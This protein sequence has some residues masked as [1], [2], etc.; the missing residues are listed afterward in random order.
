MLGIGSDFT[1]ARPL[2]RIAR[3]ESYGTLPQDNF[4]EGTKRDRGVVLERIS[5]HELE[6]VI[7][8]H[9]GYLQHL[10][11]HLPERQ[12]LRITHYHGELK[13]ELGELH[14]KGRS[15]NQRQLR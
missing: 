15:D 10:R 1:S 9:L 3:C 13:A 12:H 6:F 14:A 4:A 5:R 7:A 8:R 11:H 2:S